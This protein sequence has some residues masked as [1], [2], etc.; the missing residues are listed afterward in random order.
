MDFTLG[1]QGFYT[2]INQPDDQIHLARA[3]LYIAEEEY[4]DLA[5][6]DYL[7][8][9]DVMASEV[10]E[11]LPEQRYPLR[12]IKTLNQ[13]FYDDL[14]YSG[15]S[16]D[17][18]DPRNSFLN[19]VMDRR[20][21][22][23]ISLSVVYLEV[24]RRLDFPM[25]GIGMPGHFL[26]RPEFEQVGIFVDAFDGGEI[27]FE[28]DCEERLTQIYGHPVTLQPSFLAPVSNRQLLA[29]MLMNLKLIYLNGQDLPRALAA[30]ERMLLLFPNAPVQLRDRGLI[31]SQLGYL[32]EACQDLEHYL[33][34][35]PQAEDAD[36]IR[37][38]LQQIGNL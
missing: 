17:Y 28:Q 27:L 20:T 1:R 5:I 37:R 9:L 32:S 29:R 34:I 6:D 3:A 36:I 22:I 2:E 10:E 30:V 38:L 33:E 19:Q 4:P 21:G 18:Y 11:R 25:V 12:V 13:Y 14:G 26:I 7:N 8:A 16:S 31:Y 24:A 23:P 35:L 15:N